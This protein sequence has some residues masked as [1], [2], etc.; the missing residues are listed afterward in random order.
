[1]EAILLQSYT[2]IRHIL[3]IFNSFSSLKPRTEYKIIKNTTKMHWTVFF[4]QNSWN[5]PWADGFSYNFSRVSY[6][7]H[8]LLF[9]RLFVPFWFFTYISEMLSCTEEIGISLK[10]SGKSG[11][12]RLDCH[13][14]RSSFHR[15]NG[16][17]EVFYVPFSMC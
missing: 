9:L 11:W 3:H 2:K 15:W 10:S 12:H 6:G 16:I 7:F 4:V 17:Y 13:P 5:K 14:I 8:I 1:M